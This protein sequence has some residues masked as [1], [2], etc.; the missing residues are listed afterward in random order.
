MRYEL[1]IFQPKD[2]GY[3][4]RV[5]ESF[6]L[7]QAM[8]LI[9][10]ELSVVEPGHVEIHLPFKPE[11]TQQHGFI[12]GGVVGMIADSAAGY[13]AN[14]LTPAGTS[15]LTVEYK[16]NL[17]APADGERLVAR[18]EVVKPGRTLLITRA[19]VFAIR[20]E[21]WTLCA[22]MQQTIMAM[23]GRKEGIE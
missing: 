2:P 17:L 23:H 7:Q 19:E 10:A 1:P 18:G 5:R 4:D 12:H 20:R 14:T 6:R 22:V 16:L 11:I 13:A 9:G 8:A 15:V 21:Q 3:A